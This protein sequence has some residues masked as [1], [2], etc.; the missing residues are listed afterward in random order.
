MRKVRALEVI[1]DNFLRK[2][3]VGETWFPATIE[4]IRHMICVEEIEDN[5]MGFPESFN[6][7]YTVKSGGIIYFSIEN[8]R[9]IVEYRVG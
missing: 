9:C 7:I 8:C 4:G 6:F 1:G 5:S 3:V 2:F